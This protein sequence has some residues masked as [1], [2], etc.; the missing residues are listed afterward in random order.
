MEINKVDSLQH[1][2]GFQRAKNF[3]EMKTVYK[4]MLHD[5]I[6]TNDDVKEEFS[7][8]LGKHPNS[9]VS[10]GSKEAESTRKIMINIV[11]KE[12][13]SRGLKYK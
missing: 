12:M 7:K 4:N 13:K 9:Y 8:W 5:T 1:K 11:K 2:Y 10:N 6:V 3:S